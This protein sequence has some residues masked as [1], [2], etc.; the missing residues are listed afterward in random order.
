MMGALRMASPTLPVC[1]RLLVRH[2]WV[3][4]HGT[5]RVSALAGPPATG[6]AL[7]L[8]WLG[9]SGRAADPLALRVEPPRAGRDWLEHVAPEA[10]RLVEQTPQRPVAIAA[11]AATFSAWLAER[12]DRAA[13]L[14]AEGMIELTGGDADPVRVD[15][16]PVRVVVGP[17][18]DAPP[19][20]VGV[21]D[22]AVVS[23]GAVASD[24][25]RLARARSLAELTLHEALAATASTAGR[26]ELNQL[27]GFHFG[28]RP[29]EVDLL[30]RRDRVA[31]EIDGHHHFTSL[32]GYRRDRRKDLLLQARGFAVIR[33]LADDVLADPRA[34][35]R[36]VCE[37]LAQRM[38]GG[39]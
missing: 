24:P 21:P 6:Q 29:A 7:W 36:A 10:V 23:D 1:M 20:R 2:Q 28:G 27:V 13:A 16:E 8:D 38:G 39:R 25:A 5:P 34:A 19:V 31:I 17:A 37:L 32:D 18:A 35:V 3:R 4:E 22:P 9:L 11:G 15:A 14:I 33:F 30:S 12:R 26:F